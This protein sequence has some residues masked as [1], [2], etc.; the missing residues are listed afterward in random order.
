MDSSLLLRAQLVPCPPRV[1]AQP[2]IITL[3]VPPGN[4]SVRVLQ[5][6]FFSGKVPDR[7]GRARPRGRL[8]QSHGMARECRSS[9]SRGRRRRIAPKNL[10][11]IGTGN[12]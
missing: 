10:R 12:C 3:R 7:E 6:G 1:Q 4:F 9:V 2:D 11:K 5:A 8:A